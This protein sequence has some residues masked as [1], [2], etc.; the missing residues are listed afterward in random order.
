VRVGT[1]LGAARLRGVAGELLELVLEAVGIDA[2]QAGGGLR[3]EVADTLGG[4]QREE[5][6]ARS[7]AVVVELQG[8]D[9]PG[10]LQRHRDVLGE[11]RHPLVAALE[12]GEGGLELFVDLGRVDAEVFEN[13]EEIRAL[14]LQ[15][16]GEEVLEL[17]GVVSPLNTHGRGVFEALATCGVEDGDEGF[18]IVGHQVRPTAA[19]RMRRARPGGGRGH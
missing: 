7:H 1:G 8:G 13:S 15:E 3:D 5:D 14:A 2:A 6:G 16:A 19:L 18:E 10:L 11:G 17:D 4:A 12:G 9:E